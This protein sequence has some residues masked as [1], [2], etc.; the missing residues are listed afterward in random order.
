MSNT[1][2]NKGTVAAGLAVAIVIAGA[3]NF[4]VSVIAHAA[5]ASSEFMALNPPV[6]IAFTVVGMLIGAVGWNLVRTKANR[7]NAVLR[8]LV[9]V[10]L[11]V[12]FVPDLLL[13][14]KL[15]GSTTGGVVALMA[16]HLLVFIV[17]VPAFIR[18]LPL[19]AD[20]PTSDVAGA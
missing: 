11:V 5:G 1:Q 3:A 15:P 4:G 2:T 9:P 14:G 19:P 16:M 17:A 18:V 10:V 6:L 8:V 13:A 20:A 12:S 7:P